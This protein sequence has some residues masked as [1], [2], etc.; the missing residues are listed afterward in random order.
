MYENTFFFGCSVTIFESFES[1]V[2]NEKSPTDKYVM[3][4]YIK[5]DAAYREEFGLTDEDFIE[6]YR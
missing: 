1:V 4:R 5:K 2:T 6:K 3:I